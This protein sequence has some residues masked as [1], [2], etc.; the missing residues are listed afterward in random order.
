MDESSKIKELDV[1]LQERCILFLEKVRSLLKAADFRTHDG[2][3]IED[4]V[5]TEGLRDIYYQA[6]LYSI[7]RSYDRNTRKWN[8]LDEGQLV[9]RT[10]LSKHLQ[11]KAFDIAMIVNKQTSWPS[12]QYDL[13]RKAWLTLAEVGKQCGLTP[14]AYFSKP[15]Y[16]HYEF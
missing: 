4:V 8:V 5:L 1:F 9:T 11:G 15:D 14:G 6:G 16:P 7:G 2:K 3:R 13:N 12:A 10:L